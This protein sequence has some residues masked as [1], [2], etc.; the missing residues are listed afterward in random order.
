MERRDFLRSTAVGATAPLLLSSA[1]SGQQSSKM[2]GLWLRK[3]EEDDFAVVVRIL[4]D[5]QQGVT[6]RDQLEDSEEDVLSSISQNVVSTGKPLVDLYDTSSP[7]ALE[8]SLN[9]GPRLANT[10]VELVFSVLEQVEEAYNMDLPREHILAASR[11]A[12]LLKSLIAATLNFYQ[13]CEAIVNSDE[14]TEPL[15]RDF[16]YSLLILLV[17]VVLAKYPFDY[18]IAWRTTRYVHNQFLVRARSILGSSGIAVIMKFIHWGL[19]RRQVSVDF[20]ESFYDAIVAFA[21]E[22]GQEIYERAREALEGVGDDY[23]LERTED[24]GVETRLEISD[25]VAEFIAT[26]LIEP[27]AKVVEPDEGQRTGAL[28]ESVMKYYDRDT[29]EA[30][31]EGDVGEFDK[32]VVDLLFESE[33]GES[34]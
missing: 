22:Q 20:A 6:D 28:R 24:Y 5:Y 31:G 9:Y 21:L 18:W 25:N 27:V 26:N 14:L 16:Y 7:D 33:I 11:R 34:A 10:D 4:L 12:F 15:R 13:A 8:H 30:I 2:D 32:S 19:I 23:V 1:V 17:E 3:F 29:L